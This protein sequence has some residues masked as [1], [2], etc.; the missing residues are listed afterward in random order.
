[1]SARDGY[2]PGVPCWVE[3]LQ[4]EVEPAAAFYGSLFGWDLEPGP[5]GSRLARLRGR[6]VAGDRAAAAGR[7]AGAGAGW[8][9]HVCVDSAER[10]G[11]RAAGAGGSVLAPAFDVAPVGR[12]AVVADPAGA[13]LCLWEPGLR[14]GAQRVNEPGAWS[15]SRSTPPIRTGRPPS[16]APSSAGRPRPSSS[17][18]RPSRCSACPGLRRRRARAARLA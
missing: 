10:A 18:R 14:Q 16:I 2:E 12:M 11:E 5:G 9:T 3:A 13:V 8:H 6:D 15:M 7:D 17:G 1:M 4:P